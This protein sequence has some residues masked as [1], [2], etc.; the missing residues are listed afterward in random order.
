MLILISRTPHSPSTKRKK[1]ISPCTHTRSHVY[2][3]KNPPS[4]VFF[5]R[6]GG[7]LLFFQRPH[8]NVRTKETNFPVKDLGAI[9]NFYL[10]FLYSQKIGYNFPIDISMLT[11]VHPGGS[12]FFLT[13][14]FEK[15]K[16]KKKLYPVK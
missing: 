10:I 13:L 12:F 11:Y 4:C 14:P 7:L 3:L 2:R 16:K 1:Y 8:R 5:K 15:L 6:H 9:F